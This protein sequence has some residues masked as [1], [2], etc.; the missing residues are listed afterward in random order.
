MTNKTRV[1]FRLRKELD[2]DLIEA[3]EHLT[4]GELSE[5]SRDG[6]RLM[7]GI[8]T[9]KQV[10]VVEKIITPPE[11]PSKPMVFVQ[12]GRVKG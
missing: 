7:L 5:L 11:R 3:T 1:A 6:L 4:E 12:Q 8:K 2:A 10:E 9:S